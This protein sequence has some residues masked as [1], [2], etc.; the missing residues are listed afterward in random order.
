[1]STNFIIKFKMYN[2]ELILKNY[3]SFEC[4]TKKCREINNIVE[5]RIHADTNLWGAKSQF[6]Q[7]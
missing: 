3:I 2:N 6:Q 7:F 5:L 1:M 4:A